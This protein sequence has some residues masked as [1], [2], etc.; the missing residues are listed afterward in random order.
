MPR[1]LPVPKR[2]S[3]THGVSGN[4]GEQHSVA[5]SGTSATAWSFHK[6][7]Q[8]GKATEESSLKLLKRVLLVVSLTVAALSLIAM[9]ISR[10][11]VQQ[12]VSD[13][14]TLDLEGKRIAFHQVRSFASC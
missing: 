12:G 5:S 2:N 13:I 8:N 11:V 7:I 14:S 1:G 3:I 9:S 10:T 4:N 6:A